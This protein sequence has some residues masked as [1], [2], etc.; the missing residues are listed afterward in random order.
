MGSRFLVSL[1]GSFLLTIVLLG[2]A[3]YGITA[4]AVPEPHERYRLGQFDFELAPGWSC[5]L[6]GT[7]HV[8]QAQGSKKQGAIAVIAVKARNDKDTLAEY[9]A[10][11]RKPQN[12]TFEGEAW[13][14]QVKTIERRK[15]GGRE[16]VS[17]LHVGSEIKDFE[18]YYLGTVT[19]HFGMLVTMS[20]HK[21]RIAEYA[22]DFEEMMSTLNVYQR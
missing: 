21:D 17:A 6:D 15:I 22:Q 1:L 19:S 7:E 16:W 2:G 14:S 18:T 12:V 3:G 11:L 8:C 20:A 9:E 13:V 10:H 4:F 5:D